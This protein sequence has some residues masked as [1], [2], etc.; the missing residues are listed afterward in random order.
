M[1]LLDALQ[2]VN[3]DSMSAAQLTDMCV[4]TVVSSSPLEIEMDIHQAPLREEVLILTDEVKAKTVDVGGASY[5]D[6][7]NGRLCAVWGSGQQHEG[8]VVINTA[9]AVGDK[10]LMLS[11]KH[12]QQFIVLSRL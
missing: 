7:V 2:Q 9:L 3:R 1:T 12:G 8:E 10:V 5:F 6:D 4:G 11:V